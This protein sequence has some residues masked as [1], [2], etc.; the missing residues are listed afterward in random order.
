MK[1]LLFIFA[2]LPVLWFV[3]AMNFSDPWLTDFE[4]AK[5][6]SKKSGKPILLYFSGSDWCGVC[7]KFNKDVLDQDAF[8]DYSSKNLVLLQ[9]DFPRMK[10]NKLDKKLTEQNESLAERYNP[11]GVFPSTV[12]L[13]SEGKVIKEWQGYPDLKTEQFIEQ[14]KKCK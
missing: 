12:L 14:I 2:L 1:K 4:S 8:K 13:N 7:M 5:A 3:Y 6:E 11:S 9:A 10:K